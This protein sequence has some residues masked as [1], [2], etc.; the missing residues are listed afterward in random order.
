MKSNTFI[1]E[2]TL[3][4]AR[5]VVVNAPITATY[6]SQKYKYYFR[7]IP[8]FQFNNG[9]EQDWTS[10]TN[11][12]ASFKNDWDPVELNELKR[13][14]ESL[15]LIESIGPITQA[16]LI[17]ENAPVEAVGFYVMYGNYFTEEERD[18][19]EG[20]YTLSLDQLRQ[21]IVDYENLQNVMNEIE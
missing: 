2:N 15:N 10:T 18:I 3:D 11:N 14:I 1:K 19:Y 5:K 7:E 16:K 6:Y 21:A 20:M 12:G 9:Y 17:V 4:T 13:I 8:E